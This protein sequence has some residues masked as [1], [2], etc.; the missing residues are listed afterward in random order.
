MIHSFYSILLH[1]DCFLRIYSNTFKIHLIIIF[2]NII[3]PIPPMKPVMNRK[4]FV[5]SLGPKYCVMPSIATGTINIIDIIKVL[6]S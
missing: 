4:L 3:K 5:L 1:Q 2:K 6:M